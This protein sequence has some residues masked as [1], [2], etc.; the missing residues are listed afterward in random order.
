MPD[1]ENKWINIINPKLH[2]A[3]YIIISDQNSDDNS[4]DIVRRYEKVR[5]I[6]N[7]YT[8]YDE[9]YAW[10]FDFMYG[11]QFYYA[12]KTTQYYAIAVREG[13]VPQQPVA[14]EP[15]SSILFVTGGTLLA[16]RRFIRRKA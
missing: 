10:N 13:D 6:K 11:D 15:I 12:G 8:E 14:P 16:G 4:R 7:S 9:Y 3:D 2:Q 5:L 1:D